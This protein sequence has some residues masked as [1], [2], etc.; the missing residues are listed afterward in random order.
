[1]RGLLILL[2]TCACVD[3]QAQVNII[4][5]ICGNDTAGYGG[6]GG[7]AIGAKLNYPNQLCLDNSGNLYIADALNHRIRKIVLSTGIIT[8]I[9]GTGAPGYNGDN[10]PA[11]D[12]QLLVPD[13]VCIDTFGNVFFADGLNY[14]VRKV[15]VSTGII[16]TIAGNG[17]AGNIGNGVPATNAR[18]RT[19]TGMC[20]DRFG[21][22]YISDLDNNNIRRISSDGII[23]TIAGSG[24]S[25]Y[26]G[27]NGPATNARFNSPGDV[28]I[29]TFGNLFICDGYNNAVRKVDGVTGIITTIAG[30]GAPGYA[31]DNGPASSALLYQPYGIFINMRNDIY[32]AEWQNGVIRKINAETNIITTVAGTGNPGFCCDGGPATNAQLKPDD[33]CIDTNGTMYIADYGNQRIRKVY[34]PTLAIKPVGIVQTIS[35]YPNPANNELTIEGAQNTSMVLCDVVGKVVMER[36]LNS[37]KETIDISFLNSGVYVV[38]IYDAVSGTKTAKKLVKQ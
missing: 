26:W 8:T 13:A 12:A 27:D 3:L 6:D 38:Q 4:S 20:I 28:A 10:I 37:A 36:K 31:G 7:P 19:P 32:F 15:N 30:N 24:I 34:D 9:A 35:V 14:R 23:K 33:V 1:M 16:T 25:G 5:T 21:N 2:F 22:I 18:I 11:T 29:D 17:T